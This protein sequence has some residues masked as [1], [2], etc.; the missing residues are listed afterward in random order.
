RDRIV[1]AGTEVDLRIAT[2]RTM[3]GESAVIRLLRK[4]SGFVAL[5]QIGLAARDDSILRNALQAP[6]GMV[7][8]TGP[9]GSGKTTT[10]AASLAVMMTMPNGACSALRRK[11]GRAHV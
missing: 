10:L 5:D 1:V 9:T 6:F 2:M 7:I 3:H 8:V 11:I 4:G